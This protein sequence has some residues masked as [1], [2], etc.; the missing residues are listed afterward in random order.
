MTTVELRVPQGFLLPTIL[1]Q[2]TP[3]ENAIILLTA[4][5]IITSLRNVDYQKQ[6]DALREE[7]NRA[8]SETKKIR[9]AIY[10]IEDR[11]IE[12]INER[13]DEINT[14]FGGSIEIPPDPS[15]KELSHKVDRLL[16]S[17]TGVTLTEKLMEKLDAAM[18]ELNQ[19]KHKVALKG[20]MNEKDM[21]ELIVSTFA[22]PG[23]NFIMH[24]KHIRSGD[25]IF[26]WNGVTIMWEDKDYQKDV[27]VKEVEKALRDIEEHPECSVLIFVSKN[28]M[29]RGY[30]SSDNIKVVFY[31][32]RLVIFVS[33][34]L[35]NIDLHGYVKRV[36][37]PIIGAARPVIEQLKGGSTVS[38]TVEF[39]FTMI[40]LITVCIEQQEQHLSKMLQEMKGHIVTVSR[41]LYEQRGR[42]Q[43]MLGM[44]QGRKNIQSPRI[45]Q[46][47]ISNNC[48]ADI[49]PVVQHT[50]SNDDDD[51]FQA[52]AAG[53]CD[54]CGGRGH[55]DDICTSKSTNSRNCG[56]CG[57]K[58]HNRTNCPNLK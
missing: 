50:T 2:S 18:A 13:L 25:H 33:N 37:Q 56:E 40:P 47:T 27:Q 12:A 3:D 57:G 11:I 58:G 43:D 46:A 39:A 5:A 22:T 26:T 7:S 28:T 10:G 41:Q 30:E 1:S 4:P 52:R 23:A 15:I 34:F 45:A 55:T 38:N 9:D 29:I 35:Q 31:G 24:D 17:Q 20:A 51:C 42:L 16:A 6:V 32:H 49:P 54:K 48:N 21:H 36:L 44:L 8:R 53:V 19:N 14:E